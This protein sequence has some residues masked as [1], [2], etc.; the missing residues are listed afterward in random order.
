MLSLEEFPDSFYFKTDVVY[1]TYKGGRDFSAKTL[2]I[3]YS[4]VLDIEYNSLSQLLFASYSAEAV[5]LNTEKRTTFGVL[6]ETLQK[7]VEENREV[8]FLSKVNPKNIDRR[9][10]E[11]FIENQNVEQRVFISTKDLK[12]H[13]PGIQAVET[14]WNTWT[15]TYSEGKAMTMVIPSELTRFF[16]PIDEDGEVDDNLGVQI[17]QFVSRKRLLNM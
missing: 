15:Q 16:S 7:W 5:R 13:N 11:T 17:C 2:T 1:Y 14:A 3:Y 12:G 4:D 6:S 9:Q 10:Y 8:A